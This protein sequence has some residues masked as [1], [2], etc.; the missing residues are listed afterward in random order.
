MGEYEPPDE[1]VDKQLDRLKQDAHIQYIDDGLDAVHDD[2]GYYD[3]ADDDHAIHLYQETPTL[4]QRVSNWLAW[5]WRWFVLLIALLI[6]A[7]LLMGVILAATSLN[8]D[9]SGPVGELL[10][11]GGPTATAAPVTGAW[12]AVDFAPHTVPAMIRHEIVG[13]GTAHGYRFEGTAGE[14]WQIMVEPSF[15]SAFDPLLRVYASS[16]EELVMNDNRAPG[17]VSAEVVTILPANGWY[18]VVVRS[19]GEGLT[20]GEYWLMVYEQ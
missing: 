11:P 17:D 9:S 18:R 16:G 20:V 6:P 1:W 5:Q 15:G 19:A 8:R 12:P 7:M 13:A 14:A 10:A 4:R 2:D 3:G